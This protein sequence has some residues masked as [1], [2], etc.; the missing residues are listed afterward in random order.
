MHRTEPN[1]QR[2]SDW[3]GGVEREE[4]REEELRRS[5]RTKIEIPGWAKKEIHYAWREWMALASSITVT[6]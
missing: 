4:E 6:D 1:S 5:E 2:E 3:R